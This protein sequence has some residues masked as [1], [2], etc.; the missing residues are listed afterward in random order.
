MFE[1][2]SLKCTYIGVG[3]ILVRLNE[4]TNRR[5]IMEHEQMDI[6]QRLIDDS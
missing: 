3:I 2:I 5:V 1:I 6:E 4:S